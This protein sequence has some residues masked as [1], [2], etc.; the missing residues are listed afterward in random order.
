MWKFLNIASIFLKS[1]STSP[2]NK[3]K[4]SWELFSLKSRKWKAHLRIPSCA[5][6]HRNLTAHSAIQGRRVASFTG[7]GTTINNRFRRYKRRSEM[8]WAGHESRGGTGRPFNGRA[9]S[10]N[11]PR[12]TQLKEALGFV[13]ANSC[14]ACVC[15]DRQLTSTLGAD[16]RLPNKYYL[17]FHSLHLGG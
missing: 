2:D 4:L 9:M 8:L 17:C 6:T 10:R 11:W 14:C 12:A 5:G 13:G 16:T 3:T 1:Y 7:D 15:A